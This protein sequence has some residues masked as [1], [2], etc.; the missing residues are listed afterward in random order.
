MFC[1]FCRMLGHDL[2]HCAKH[3][4]LRKNIREVVC[5]YGDCLKANGGQN[6]SHSWKMTTNSEHQH[7]DID[8]GHVRSNSRQE[9][10]I[11]GEL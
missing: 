11:G 1:H 4:T 5:Q 3:F 7:R 6:Q 10:E 2:K 8:E 9:A